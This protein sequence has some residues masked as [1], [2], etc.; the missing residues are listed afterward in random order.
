MLKDKL[1]TALM[2]TLLEGTKDF[3]VY[4]DTSRVGLRCVLMKHGKV[5]AMPL[6]NLR[7]MRETIPLMTSS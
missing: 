4:S 3:V 6:D 1:T 5:I 2:L 7:Y